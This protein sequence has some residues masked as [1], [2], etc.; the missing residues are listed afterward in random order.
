[1]DFDANDSNVL[2]TLQNSKNPDQVIY[3][4]RDEQKDY[5]ETQGLRKLFG[6]DELR[7]KTSEMVRDVSEYA[8]VLSFLMETMSAARELGLPYMYQD[9]F[10]YANA[11]YS[12]Y[13]QD[14]YR[15]LTRLA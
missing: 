9:L 8:Q 10:E 12:L 1:M 13:G 6:V 15:L 5:V 2:M 3:V 7:I 14:G 4:I 11:R